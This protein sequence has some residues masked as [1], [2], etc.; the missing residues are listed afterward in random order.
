[1]QI[2]NA[3]KV[4]HARIIGSRAH[5]M[6]NYW[7]SSLIFMM[8][9]VVHFQSKLIMEFCTFRLWWLLIWIFA[10]CGEMCI[11]P[12]SCWHSYFR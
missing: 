12:K 11:F 3:F 4:K 9:L 8:T 2:C 7:H 1:M 6:F 5:L 10:Y